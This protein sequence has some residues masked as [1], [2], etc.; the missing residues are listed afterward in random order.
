MDHGRFLRP[1]DKHS[2][3][4][5]TKHEKPLLVNL[6]ALAIVALKKS[7]SPKMF[8]QP[9]FESYENWATVS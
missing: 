7:A 6:N 5:R 4:K 9:D 8:V 3:K 1:D 2:S